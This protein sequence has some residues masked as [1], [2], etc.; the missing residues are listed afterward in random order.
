[1]H[2]PNKPLTMSTEH[3]VVFTAFLSTPGADMEDTGFTLQQPLRCPE[4]EPM[5]TR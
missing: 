2:D 5:V 3:Y 4:Y 1:M